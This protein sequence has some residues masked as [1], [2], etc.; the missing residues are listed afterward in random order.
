M[1]ERAHRVMVLG[2]GG[3]FVSAG[4]FANRHAVLGLVEVLDQ[5]G[6]R[7]L[8]AI[9]GLQQGR[10][11]LRRRQRFL[12]DINDRL[13]H[14]AQLRVGERNRRIVRRRPGQQIVHRNRLLRVPSFFGRRLLRFRRGRCCVCFQFFHSRQR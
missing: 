13:H 2:L 14:R 5:P 10:A 9:H 7:F 8:D 3:H 6:Q 12:G 4:H 1:D 11:N